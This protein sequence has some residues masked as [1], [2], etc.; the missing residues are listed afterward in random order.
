MSLLSSFIRN[1]LLKAV[2]QEFHE[3][4]PH[5]KELI[6]KEVGDFASECVAWVESKVSPKAEEVTDN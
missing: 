1:Q 3:H 5:I 2:E 6:I 4:E